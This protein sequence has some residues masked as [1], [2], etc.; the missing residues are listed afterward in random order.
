M[1]PDLTHGQ[2]GYPRSDF[3]NRAHLHDRVL[4]EITHFAKRVPEQLALA[5]RTHQA[6]LTRAPNFQPHDFRS[7]SVHD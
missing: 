4:G 7:F 6:K 1:I 5:P 2:I 3:S